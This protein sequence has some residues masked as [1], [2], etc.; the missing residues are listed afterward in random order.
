MSTYGHPLMETLGL[1]FVQP[2]TQ[3]LSLSEWLAPR[4]WSGD[5]P[6]IDADEAARCVRPVGASRLGA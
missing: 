3:R 5:A 2:L 4:G 6:T 1:D